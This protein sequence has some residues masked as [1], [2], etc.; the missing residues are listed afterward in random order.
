VLSHNIKCRQPCG[1]DYRISVGS[2]AVQEFG[3]KLDRNDYARVTV[4]EDPATNTATR[5]QN[6]D[7]TPVC[8]QLLGCGQT[9][10][11][12]TDDYRVEH[13]S[14]IHSD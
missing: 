11:T 7:A 5:L 3:A 1:I 8:A 4:S 13:V 2:G 14:L 12:S 10:R 6:N 9:S